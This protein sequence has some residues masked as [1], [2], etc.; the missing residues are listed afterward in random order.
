MG[1]LEIYQ[2]TRNNALDIDDDELAERA[3]E[4]SRETLS[5]IWDT[6]KQME[7]NNN[8]E[9]YFHATEPTT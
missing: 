7:N 3:Q 2:I 4:L 6:R 5:Q 9:L 1:E 8:K